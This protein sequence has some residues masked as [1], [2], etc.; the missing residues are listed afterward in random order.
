MHHVDI[1]P[2]NMTFQEFIDKWNGKYCEIAGSANAQNQCVD[3]ANAYIREVLSLPIIEW[4][5][6]VDFPS[7]AGDKY[8]Y[9]LNTPT[10]VPQKGD[11]IIWKPTPGHIAIFIEGNENRFTS[12]DQNFPVGSKCHIQEHNYTNVTGWLRCK[13]PPQ[14]Q[15]SVID[16]LRTARDTNWTLYQNQINETIKAKERISE[17]ERGL[18]ACES[19][20]KQF[21]DATITLNNKIADLNQAMEKDAVEDADVTIKL[22]DAELELEDVSAQLETLLKALGAKDWTEGLSVIDQLRE[23][24]EEVISEWE[25]LYDWVFTDLIAKRL[26]KTKSLIQKIIDRIRG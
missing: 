15:N 5:N 4:T 2:L 6:A 22:K 3:L 7:R 21:Q 16:E 20:K 12:F 17:L 26:P 14:N 18:N 8:E 1:R 13:N 25:K 10:G 9:I 23:P 19:E 11:L 24:D